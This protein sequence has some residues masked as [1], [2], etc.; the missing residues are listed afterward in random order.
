MFLNFIVFFK[1]VLLIDVKEYRLFCFEVRF[2]YY[3]S[4]V[5]VYFIFMFIV[6]CMMEGFVYVFIILCV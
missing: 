5:S 6:I 1:V 4:D 2:F 3:D